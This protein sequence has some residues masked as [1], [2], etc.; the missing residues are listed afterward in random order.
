MLSYCPIQG[1]LLQEL[2]QQKAALT[3]LLEQQKLQQQQQEE[4]EE[5]A[6]HIPPG[7]ADVTA[8]DISSTCA[9]QQHDAAPALCSSRGGQRSGRAAGAAPPQRGMPAAKGRSRPPRGRQGAGVADVGEAA[10][11][12]S[13]HVL[14]QALMWSSGAGAV[15][16]AAVVAVAHGCRRG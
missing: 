1:T 8:A 12:G 5:A 15:V 16:V 6:S 7:D 9:T 2:Q 10:A 13:N 4:E 11:E 14:K 3:Q